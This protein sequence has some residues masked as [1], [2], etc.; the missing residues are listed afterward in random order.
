MET[1]N[2]ATSVVDLALRHDWSKVREL[3]VNDVQVLFAT[4]SAAGFDSKAVVPGKLSGNYRDQDGRATGET[5]PINELCPFKVVGQED[6]GDD[7]DNYR[8]TGWLDCVIRRVVF[9][10]N[11]KN[12][13]RGQLIEA[14]TQEIER[15]VPLTPVQLTPE[16]DLLE[17]SS[18]MSHAFG[19]EYLVDHTRDDHKL[20]SCVG[21][22]A[23]CNGWV[24][25]TRATETHDALICRSCHM[26]V[27]FPKNVETYGELRQ[28]LVFKHISVPA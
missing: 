27:L 2:I 7:Y 24:D 3:P 4:V 26:R 22:H 16:G 23:R 12:E 10:S 25:R 19:L 28:A 17:E 15:S 9:G 13:N 14:I 6:D 11:R 8:A 21:T 18:P 1:A 5:Y 20:S